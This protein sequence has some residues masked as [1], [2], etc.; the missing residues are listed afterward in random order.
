MT[1]TGPWH[2]GP[3][4]FGPSAV[5]LT[6]LMAWLIWVLGWLCRRYRWARIPVLL[7]PVLLGSWLGF[8]ALSAPHGYAAAYSFGAAWLLAIVTAV[9]AALLLPWRRSRRPGLLGFVGA[10]TILGAFYAVYLVGYGLDL[11]AWKHK[12]RVDIPATQGR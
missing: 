1:Q 7:V 8:A 4:T 12:E 6:L 10:V 5:A 11:H 3:L 9:G 2:L